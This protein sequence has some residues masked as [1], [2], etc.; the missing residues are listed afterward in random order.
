MK[1][2]ISV[3]CPVNLGVRNGRL[4]ACPDSPNC[5]SSQTVQ[6]A[7]SKHFIIPLEFKGD[8]H[9]E[10]QRL[11]SL[12]N[13][14]KGVTIISSNDHYFHAECKTPFMGFIDD[15]EFYWSKNEKLCHVRS[16]SRIG[17]SDLGVNR[18]RV[19]KI[20]KAFN[21]QALD[22]TPHG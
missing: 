2:Y 11:K 16:A 8:P 13:S 18:R 9:S 15:I 14:M 3:K 1:F 10:M 5:V 20:R 7:D 4:S 21:Q 12:I 6:Q 22:N 19:D 17:Y